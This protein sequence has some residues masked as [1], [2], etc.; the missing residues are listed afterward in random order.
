MK[1]RV[2]L[3][4]HEHGPMDDRVVNYCLMNGIKPDI[5][6]PFAGD[7]LGEIEED[8][9]GTVVYGGNYNADSV[10]EN[11]FLS[12]EYRWIGN[13][14]DAG[15]PLL[16]ICQGALMIAHHQ[17]AW[18]G[19][20]AEGTYEFGYYKVSPTLEGK[21]FL[22]KPLYMTQAHFHT[23]DLPVGATHLASSD[24]FENQA[25]CIGNTVYGVQFH[26]EKTIE[27]FRR[28]QNAK[29]GLYGR[30]NVQS[31]TLQTELMYAHDAAQAE[32]FYGFLAAFLK[33]D[34]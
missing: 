16:G 15:I 31:T 5:R 14:I 29:W 4:R 7:T 25:F 34:E 19:S 23:F 28:W 10:K 1:S 22:P 8:V 18:A 27:G 26:P 20:R 12:E 9:I 11:A 6:Y 3:V 17:G 13:A 24:T 30:P 32:W 2:V 33:K 21:S